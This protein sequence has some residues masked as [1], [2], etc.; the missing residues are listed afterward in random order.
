MEAVGTTGM[1]RSGRQLVRGPVTG[2]TQGQI[3]ANLETRV[4]A[5][6]PSELRVQE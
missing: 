2:G 1:E 5:D 4:L 6:V 3:L